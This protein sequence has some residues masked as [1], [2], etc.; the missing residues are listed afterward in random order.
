MASEAPITSLTPRAFEARLPPRADAVVIGG[1]I[2]GVMAA[3][4]LRRRGL[5]VVL[6]EKGRIAGEQSSRNWGWV[7]QQGR[8]PVEL[9]VMV[10]AAGAWAGLGAAA[11]ADLGYRREGVLYLA[12]D[13]KTMAR[14]ERWLEHARTHQLGS[15][16]LARR[17]VRAL[18]PEAGEGWLGGLAG[19][20]WTPGD[21]RAEPGVA[22]PALARAL[23]RDGVAVAEDCAVRALDLAGGRVAGVVTERGRIACDAVVLAGGAWSALFLGSL[24]IALPQLAVRATVAATLPMPD[25]FPGNAAD[26]AFAFRRRADGGYTLAPGAFHELFLGPDAL[27]HARA[28][29]PELRANPFGTRFLPAAPAGY[30]DAWRTPRAWDADAPS[31]FEAARV[32]DPAPNRGAVRAFLR[33]FAR[34]FPGQTPRIRA[35]WAGMIDTMPDVLPV[36]DHA[37]GVPGL[38]IATGLSGHGFG[39]GPAIGRIAADLATGHPAGHDLRPFRATRFTDGS[40][41]HASGAL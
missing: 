26:D 3:W 4:H 35:A 19:G 29:W 36:L 10:E 38:V 27:R 22:V 13:A 12:R 25:I 24:G 5:A 9:P 15:R 8:D 41:R 31:P 40:P 2:A 30:P 6:A 17:E 32:L 7:R 37:P 28:F 18:M 14:Y 33:R 21:G 23:V 11:G 39:I 20:L 34:A 16:L 1:G